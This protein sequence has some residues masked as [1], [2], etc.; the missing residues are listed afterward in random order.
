MICLDAKQTGEIICLQSCMAQTE[1]QQG[2]KDQ[3]AAET[4]DPFFKL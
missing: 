1:D 3:K 2:R 4:A